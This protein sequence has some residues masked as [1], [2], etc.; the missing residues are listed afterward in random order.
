MLGSGGTAMLSLCGQVP[1]VVIVGWWIL[2]L[3]YV[4]MCCKHCVLLQWNGCCPSVD[5]GLCVWAFCR[6]WNEGVLGP[7]VTLVSR[8]GR[9]PS[10]FGSSMVNCMCGSCVLMWWRSCWLCYAFHHRW[11]MW[12]SVQ[13]L[14]LKLLHKEVGNEGAD[15]GTHGCTLKM[16]VILT[17]EEEVKCF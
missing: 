14:D 9:D 15:G 17:L 1:C 10:W 12:S 13:G 16:F 2:P 5:I 7:G 6:L 3:P 4:P 11:G 8:N